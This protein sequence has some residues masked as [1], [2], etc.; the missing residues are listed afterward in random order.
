VSVCLFAQ[1]RERSPVGGGSLAGS[2]A[3]FDGR[4]KCVT[5]GRTLLHKAARKGNVDEVRR[6][7]AT[8]R[9]SAVDDEGST[10]LHDAVLGGDD[11]KAAEVGLECCSLTS[12][13]RHHTF[14][15]QP[16]QTVLAPSPY[17][18]S[19]KDVLVCD[20]VLMAL[21]STPLLVIPSTEHVAVFFVLFVTCP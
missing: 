2:I 9:A 16:C 1:G 19:L 20:V 3:T 8:I 10:A 6:L 12:R 21:T 15:L 13:S 18:T 5:Y 17:A 7:L 4:G 11:L 14:Y